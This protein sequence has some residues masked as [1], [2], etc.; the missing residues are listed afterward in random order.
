[1]LSRK[2]WGKGLN[3]PTP[4]LGVACF[5]GDKKQPASPDLGAFRK[6]DFAS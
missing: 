6:V 1:M 3:P 5:I 2:G 4:A